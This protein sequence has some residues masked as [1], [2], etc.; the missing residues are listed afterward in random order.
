MIFKSKS[1]TSLYGNNNNGKD[2][3]F[4]LKAWTVLFIESERKGMLHLIQMFSGRL[5]YVRSETRDYCLFTHFKASENA[6]KIW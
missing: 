6:K 2:L 1:I 3:F 4:H 5:R